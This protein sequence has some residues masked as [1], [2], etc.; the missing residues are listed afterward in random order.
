MSASYEW[1]HARRWHGWHWSRSTGCVH[2][3]CWWPH[4]LNETIRD[5]TSSS[6]SKKGPPLNYTYTVCAHVSLC[7]WLYRKKKGLES[8]WVLPCQLFCLVSRGEELASFTFWSLSWWSN[9]GLCRGGDGQAAKN[10]SP[11]SAKREKPVKHV[12]ETEPRY[13]EQKDKVLSS[14]SPSDKNTHSETLDSSSSSKASPNKPVGPAKPA[15][16]R[17][18]QVIGPMLPPTQHMEEPTQPKVGKE[19]AF[20]SIFIMVYCITMLGEVRRS[21]LLWLATPRL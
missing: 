7:V 1:L 17:K 16:K 12:P 15:A 14:S 13:T 2:E 8:W 9:T 10:D 3:A 4:G 19:E 6:W 5:K 21:W 18:K 20:C 11:I